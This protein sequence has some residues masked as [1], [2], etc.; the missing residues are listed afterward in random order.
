[1]KNI[2]KELCIGQRITNCY[3]NNG[4]KIEMNYER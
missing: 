4:Y 1:M 2:I 3:L